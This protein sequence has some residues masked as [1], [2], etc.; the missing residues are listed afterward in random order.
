MNCLFL[1]NVRVNE[2]IKGPAKH[3]KILVVRLGSNG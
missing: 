1:K 2:N 3:E